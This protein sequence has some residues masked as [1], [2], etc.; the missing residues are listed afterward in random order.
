[1]IEFRS[2]F[3]NDLMQRF[4]HLQS[5]HSTYER[6]LLDYFNT[7]RVDPMYVPP[8]DRTLNPIEGGVHITKNAQ[9]RHPL[10]QNNASESLFNIS[11]LNL[12]AGN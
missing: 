8:L 3:K 10:I 9:Q 6:D 7:D 12:T 2:E 1:M 11:D 4:S 5:E